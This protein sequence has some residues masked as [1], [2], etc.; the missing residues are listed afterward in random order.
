M[1][2]RDFD[3][4]TPLHCAIM[5]VI[6]EEGGGDRQQGGDKKEGRS[7]GDR[8]ERGPRGYGQQ[9]LYCVKVLLEMGARV[10]VFNNHGETALHS[11]VVEG[12]MEVV[13][14]LLEHGLL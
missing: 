10:D 13:S 1:S 14:L 8:K 7:E 12:N 5:R 11:A 4:D 9:N 3:D 6:A 2:S